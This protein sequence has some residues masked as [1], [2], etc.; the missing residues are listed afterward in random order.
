MGTIGRRNRVEKRR[1]IDRG[2]S[3][4]CLCWYSR[5]QDSSGP[6]GEAQQTRFRNAQSVSE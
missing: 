3:L 5:E 1:P 2:L 6:E 4:N